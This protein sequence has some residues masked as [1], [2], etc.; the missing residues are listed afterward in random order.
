MEALKMLK[1]PKLFEP[2]KL[3]NTTFSSRLFASPISTRAL[4]AENRP[5]PEAIAFY[6]RKARGGAASVCVGDC[7]VDAAAGM[8]GGDMLSLEDEGARRALNRLTRAISRHGAVAS[9]E[10]Q[11]AGLYSRAARERGLPVYGPVGG[12][13]ADGNAILEMPEARILEIIEKFAQAAIFAKACGFGMVTLHGGHGWLLS[14]FMSSKVNTRRDRWGGSLENRMRLPLAVC[15][16]VRRAVGSGFPI[17][18]RI[19][20]SEVSPRGYDLDEGI[21]IAK[22]LDGHVDLL[23]VSAGHHE[24]PEVFCVTHPSVFARD[25]ENIRFAAAI[26]RHVAMPVASVGAHCDPELLE[27]ILASGQADV[28]ELARALLAD[29]DL[30]NK[31]RAGRAAEIRPCLRCL[32]C[33]SGLLA[34][35]QIYC[36]VNPE[37]G[38]EPEYAAALPESEPKTVLIA[39]GGVA[40]MQAAITAAR[41]GHRVV[42]CEKSERLGGALKCEEDVPFKQKIR[43]YLAYQAAQIA[44]LPVEV[45]LNTPA[46][47]ELARALAPDVIIAALGAR[48]VQPRNPG[49]DL[50]HVAAAEDVYANPE[51][52]REAGKIVILG[53]GLVGAELA[54]HLA[55]PGRGVTVVEMAPA[56]GNGGNALHQLALDVEIERRGI[57]LALG[58]KALEITPDGVRCENAAGAAFIPADTV[59]YAVGQ[60]PLIDEA[61]ALRSEAPVFR[62]VGDCSVP[63][64]ITQAT[65]AAEAAARGI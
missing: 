35:G 55:G 57:T 25:S 34:N 4:D 53:G 41:R 22:S 14:Q 5:T 29:P 18:I 28:I 50:P 46:T 38:C 40:G 3:A 21:A 59:V 47:A 33:F 9:A 15:D 13:D 23:H 54:I 19:S 62:A 45:R 31:A 10:L 39:G 52:T 20:G 11:H 36:A 17:E 16:A 24:F 1:Y 51:L 48:P 30:P 63:K 12:E 6:E 8:F 32:Q 37:I 56:L 65:A 44:A 26:K 61:L 49:I 58:T 43:D 64:N 7:V 2:I 27:E 60:S 42:L